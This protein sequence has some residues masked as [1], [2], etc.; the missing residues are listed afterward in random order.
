MTRRERLERKV[1][2]RREWA[3]GRREKAATAFRVG[4]EHRDSSGRLDW[5]LVTQPG[6][7]PERARINRA[8]DRGHEHVQVANHHESKAAGLADQLE[9]S[10][11]S[12]DPDAIEALQAKAAELERESARRVAV[13]R[14]FRKAAGA[15][16]AAKLA[17][18][19]RAGVIGEPEGVKLAR[20]FGSCH[21]EHQPYPTYSLTNLRARIRAAKARVDEVKRRAARSQQAEAAGGVH[22]SGDQYVAVTFAEKPARA[23]LEELKTAGFR[24]SGGSWCGERAKLP[25]ELRS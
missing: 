20:F 24:W 21:W 1:E 23:L 6:H 5:A 25:E 19:V 16:Q 17:E 3:E 13:N 12:D 14:A 15:D 22:I 18:L 11:F 8:H 10:I 2:R 7:I 4:D 9:R